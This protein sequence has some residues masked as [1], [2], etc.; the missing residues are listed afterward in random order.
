MKVIE[1]RPIQESTKYVDAIEAR[2]KRVFR[3]L[4]YKPLLKE[5]NLPSKTIKNSKEDLMR[6]M[7]KGEITYSRGSF[8]GKF[9]ATTSK[10]LK[11]IGAVWDKKTKAFK[12][13][14]DQIPP[15][16]KSLIGFTGEAY[17]AKIAQIDKRLAQILPE[18]IA[19]HVKIEDLFDKSLLEIEKDFQKSINKITVAPKVTAEQRAKIAKEWQ[20]NMDKWIKDFTSEHIQELRETIKKSFYAGN[21]YE[22]LV[23]EIQSSY[24]V[25][26]DKASF[27]ARQETNLLTAKYKETRYLDA[28]S[29]E[30]IWGCVNMPKDGSPNQHTPG[31]VRYYHGILE[32]K[33]FRWDDPPITN[34]NPDRRN[35]PL[36]DY[37][38]RCYARPLVNFEE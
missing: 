35:N 37:N 12:I 31:N 25:S 8:R 27:L 38:C 26:A 22:N 4:I 10:E 34:R 11:A 1:L 2:I 21:R 6:A 19:E 15:D 17:K 29:K 32:G 9:D 28:G 18:T 23:K 13:P 5:L 36:E 30:Y 14:M 24:N 33:K 3:D 20:L 7:S 16:I